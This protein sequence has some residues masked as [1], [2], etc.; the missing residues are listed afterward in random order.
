MLRSAG[1]Y[2]AHFKHAIGEA[3]A[4]CE[5]Y[6]PRSLQYAVYTTGRSGAD[7]Q[8][9][10]SLY[11]DMSATGPQLGVWLPSSKNTGEWSG[12]IRL[13][14]NHTNRLLTRRSLFDGRLV[15]FPFQ[16]GQWELQA[17]GIV[18]DDYLSRIDLG[19]ATLERGL[20]LFDATRSPSRR[21]G[22]SGRVQLGS[23]VWAVTR[24][25]L[26]PTLAPLANTACREIHE[27]G[28]W[29]MCLLD[30]PVE[31]TDETMRWLR[32]W[33]GR[34]VRAPRAKAWIESPFA[35]RIRGNGTM[36]LPRTDS[37]RFASNRPVDFDVS[38]L[39]NGRE[40]ALGRASRNAEWK[41]PEIGIWKLRVDG[42]E[43][44]HFE[45]C[46]E[47]R[48]R[49]LPI[50][51]VLE[52]GRPIDLFRLNET[53]AELA[54]AGESALGVQLVFASQAVAGL[55]SIDGKTS[56]GLDSISLVAAAGT[57]I[58]A[59]NFGRALWPLTSAN[60]FD[61]PEWTGASPI[62]LPMRWLEQF[63]RRDGRGPVRLS[64][65]T[66]SS[67]PDLERLRSLTWDTQFAVHVRALARAIKE[68]S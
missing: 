48:V 7:T 65:S 43:S 22:P 32:T 40:L 20:N 45:V 24:D 67:N 8:D 42:Y 49:P 31:A 34:D 37:I 38:S 68:S 57:H 10:F 12:A 66:L 53:F 46:D 15:V 56:I 35:I 47:I 39:A 52:N 19:P 25:A 11:F 23:T 59:K 28:G 26:F 41:M 17:E 36:M 5:N 16:S 30:L 55:V 18:N 61:K 63:A 54:R 2:S 29:H 27:Y 13:L 21:I 14:A 6:F 3:D 58:S 1:V 64:T 33:L 50:A 44:L 62:S 4:D 60:H 51:A 9:S